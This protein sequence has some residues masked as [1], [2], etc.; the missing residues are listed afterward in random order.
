M[1]RPRSMP[2][3]CGAFDRRIS[4]AL[5]EIGGLLEAGHRFGLA[6]ISDSRLPTW[7]RPLGIAHALERRFEIALARTAPA[8]RCRARRFPTCPAN[9]QTPVTTRRKAVHH[10]LQDDLTGDIQARRMNQHVRSRHQLRDILAEAEEAN[11]IGLRLRV[12]K[13]S[14]WTASFDPVR[15]QPRAVSCPS[16]DRAP[17]H[18]VEALGVS[19]RAD[20]QPDAPIFRDAEFRPD[21]RPRARRAGRAAGVRDDR[22]F[23]HG[24]SLF[25]YRQSRR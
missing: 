3:G 18:P 16:S 13:R 10:R 15:C 7:L 1:A 14:G 19:L 25:P 20:P 4:A 11:V 21:R 17:Q 12:S 2:I 9:P 6:A 22:R 24:D 23:D 5:D 8:A